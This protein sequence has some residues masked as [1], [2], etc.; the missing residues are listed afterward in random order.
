M[1]IQKYHPWRLFDKNNVYLSQHSLDAAITKAPTMIRRWRL[2]DEVQE[3]SRCWQNGCFRCLK[4]K[5]W[6][7]QCTAT[8][9]RLHNVYSKDSVQPVAVELQPHSLVRVFTHS[10]HEGAV[11][12][13]LSNE[14][15]AETHIRL[16][17]GADL[18]FS[19]LGFTAHHD[20]F[21]HFEPHQTLG[22]A[23]TGDP[24]EKHLTTRKQNLARLTC[25]L[26]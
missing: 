10:P 1:E 12:T 19:G 20:Y 24:K 15:L 26:S 23:K 17:E 21:T 9:T 4:M 3:L 8:P 5:I 25:D 11:G 18:I 16:H 2:V 22:G 7:Y 13:W 6:A 14:D